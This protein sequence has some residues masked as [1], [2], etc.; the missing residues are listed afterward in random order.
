VTLAVSNLLS[1][2]NFNYL[3][4]LK[5]Q[6][7]DHTKARIVALSGPGDLMAQLLGG[8]VPVISTQLSEILPQVKAGK[9]RILAVASPS[10]LARIPDVPTWKDLGINVVI[11]HWLGVFGPP[12]MPKV[13]V[14]YWDKKFGQMVQTKAW[15]ESM[16]KIDVYDAYLPRDE[17]AKA[18]AKEEGTIVELLKATGQLKKK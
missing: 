18:L 16:D 1:N 4:P 13:A 14:D 12:E 6:G 9:L 7:I 2:N 15:K 11:E 8:H 17:F 5:E 3:L 10:K